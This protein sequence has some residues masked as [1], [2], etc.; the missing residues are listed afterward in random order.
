ML[1]QEQGRWKH[2]S[3]KPPS[4]PPLPTSLALWIT[5]QPAE[6]HTVPYVDPPTG[7][8][9]TYQRT[10]RS[11][12]LQIPAS[13]Y[14]LMNWHL[15]WN[16]TLLS[17]VNV[18]LFCRDAAAFRANSSG[19]W[20]MSGPRM[21]MNSWTQKLKKF[22]FS[23]ILN[24]ISFFRNNYVI[25]LTVSV[26]GFSAQTLLWLMDLVPLRLLRS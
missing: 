22:I 18:C 5:K 23:A 17:L 26:P 13:P 3:L 24:F 7:R 2:H 4:S 6:N 19:F 25:Y 11:S 15:I 14:N 10:R 21:V 1:V 16:I 9:C 20:V 12:L 8:E